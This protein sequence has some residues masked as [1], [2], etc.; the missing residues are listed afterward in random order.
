MTIREF[1][2]R[3]YRQL[4]MCLEGGYAGDAADEATPAMLVRLRRSL[5]VANVD[6]S[7]DCGDPSCRSFCIAG[8][9]IS[10]GRFGCDFACTA[11]FRCCAVWTATFSTSNGCRIRRAA[12]RIAT[13]AS[14]ER[15]ARFGFARSPND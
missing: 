10:R 2:A 7:C 11:S 4:E 12:R 3:L 13:Q 5:D 9:K 1:D 6:R 8:A 15:F 14:A